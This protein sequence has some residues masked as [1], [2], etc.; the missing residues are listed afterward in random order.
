M[1]RIL[2][3]F[4]AAV[5]FLL[6]FLRF[7]GTPD[8]SGVVAPRSRG[9]PSVFFGVFFLLYAASGDSKRP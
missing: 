9:I 7:T 4:A 8:A 3:F 6:A 2:C 1:K 5:L